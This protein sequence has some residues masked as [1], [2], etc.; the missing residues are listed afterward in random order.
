MWRLRMW[1]MVE[2]EHS[3]FWHGDHE[4]HCDTEQSQLQSVWQDCT[5]SGLGSGHRLS[6]TGLSTPS[7]VDNPTQIGC[8]GE[9]YPHTLT[10]LNKV[11]DI[12]HLTASKH[13]KWNNE[14]LT[15]KHTYDRCKA[16]CRSFGTIMTMIKLTW[17]INRRLDENKKKEQHTKNSQNKINK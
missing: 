11:M 15:G 14:P 5:D 9:E 4:V 3:P 13:R 8:V 1:S 10:E 16:W 7:S 12:S 6:S 2:L 17:Q